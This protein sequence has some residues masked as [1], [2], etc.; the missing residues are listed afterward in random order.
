MYIFCQSQNVIIYYVI[1]IVIILCYPNICSLLDKLQAMLCPCGWFSF[2]FFSTEKLGQICA[3]MMLSLSLHF[4]RV[5]EDSTEG[6]VLWACIQLENHWHQ[7]AS[8]NDNTGSHQESS[9]CGIFKML[10][11]C[12]SLLDNEQSNVCTDGLMEKKKQKLRAI[13]KVKMRKK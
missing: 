6:S 12:N 9:C 4:L 8:F 7:F 2:L 11:T 1:Y 10:M 3:S 13:F 5:C